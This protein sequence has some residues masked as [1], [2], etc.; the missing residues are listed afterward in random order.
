MTRPRDPDRLVRAFLDDGPA[1]LPDR[2]LESV[3]GEVHRTPQRARWGLRRTNPMSRTALAAAAVIAVVAIGGLALWMGQPNGLPAVG[4]SPSPSAAVRPSPSAPAP[5]PTSSSI[6][7]LPIGVSANGT[8]LFGRHDPS[9]DT[10]TLHAIAPDAS[11]DVVVVPG[12]ACCLTVSDGTIG[13]AVPKNDRLV[14]SAQRLDGSWH[15]EWGSF[16]P[17]PKGQPID[18]TRL[19]LAPA[20][21]YRLDF[22]FEGWD[23]QAP[24]RTGIYLDTANG[25]GQAIGW[26]TRLTSNPGTLH[27]VPVAFSRDGAKLLFVRDLDPGDSVG[28]DLYVVDR[29]G[30]GLRRLNPSSVRVPVSD[31]FGPGASWSPDG[32]A[33]AFAGFDPGTDGASKVYVAPV[34]GGTAAAIT[35]TGSWTTSARF[36][37][38]G[39]WIAFDKG[40]GGP[41]DI[42]IVHP[43][44]TEL[45]NITSEFDVGVC[46]G[47]W[48]PDG[49]WLV[50]QGSLTGKDPESDLFIVST[51][52]PTAAR[53]TTDPTGYRSWVVWSDGPMPKPTP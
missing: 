12:D 40:M 50:V 41:H 31:D 28:G 20:A 36:S 8:I 33:V 52:D 5:S 32:T 2:V 34:T 7:S 47:Q 48:S 44:G 21:A 51:A 18:T 15:E 45:T 17:P 13:Y 46:C 10:T 11:A 27:D 42:F 19:N 53:L 25:G 14:P 24:D 23:D 26:L 4:T 22:A 39:Q 38:D 37:P 35:D 16:S 6:G 1:L 9:S 30:T 29:T 43:D 49:R 3:Q